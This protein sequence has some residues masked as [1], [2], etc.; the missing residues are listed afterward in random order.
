MN[1][2]LASASPRRRELME[3]LGV[4]NLLVIPARGEES[5]PAGLAPEE[6]VKELSRA[7]AAEVAAQRPPEDV[8][9]GADTIVELDGRILGKPADEKQ[10]AEML[11]ALS[12]REHRVFTGVTVIKGDEVISQAEMSIVRFRPLDQR[13]IAAYIATGDP[14]DK[15]GSYGVQGVACLFVS[16]I[17]GDY[18]NVMGLPLCRLGIILKKLGVEL[19]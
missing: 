1:I 3:R 11:S 2:V 4:K 10:A 13:E 5:A 14:M 18:F 8:V 9:I 12:G 16:G 19:L 7:K 6:L 17:Q 15:A